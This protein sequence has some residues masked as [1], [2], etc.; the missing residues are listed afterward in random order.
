ME[1]FFDI[2]L[3]AVS[4]FGILLAGRM[5]SN[6]CSALIT[7]E[8]KV[9]RCTNFHGTIAFDRNDGHQLDQNTR[10]RT[11]EQKLQP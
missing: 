8:F 10:A 4:V 9:H 7:A 1:V 6:Q 2:N 11:K 3:K 5:A